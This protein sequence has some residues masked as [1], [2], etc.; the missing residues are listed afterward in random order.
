MGWRQLPPATP[1]LPNQQCRFQWQQRGS[2]AAARVVLGGGVATSTI[3]TRRE[4]FLQRV[5]WWQSGRS[6]AIDGQMAS[7]ATSMAACVLHCP[8]QYGHQSEGT[9][10]PTIENSSN[11]ARHGKMGFGTHSFQQSQGCI[12]DG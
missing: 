9:I 11:G 7:L 4:E 2:R 1:P 3:F 12:R 10:V 8:S 6:P 5:K